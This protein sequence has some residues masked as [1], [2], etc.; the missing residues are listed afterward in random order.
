MTMKLSNVQLRRLIKEEI[1]T[2][3]QAP[4]KPRT[5]RL[6]PSPGIEEIGSYDA[7]N[8]VEGV[9]EAISALKTVHGILVYAENDDLADE[10][11]TAVTKLQRLKDRVQA[12]LLGPEDEF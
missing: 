6:S 1:E 9:E 10:V 2:M 3:T 8:A 4:K 7:V 11:E 12:E 5:G